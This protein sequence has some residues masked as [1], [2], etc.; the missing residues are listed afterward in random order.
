MYRYI[1]LS[2]STA[3]HLSVNTYT[4]KPCTYTCDGAGTVVS[5]DSIAQ[6]VQQFK[7]SR[8]FR[9][10]RIGHIHVPVGKVNIHVVI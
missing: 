7:T 6:A 4:Y 8:E 10:D 2:A 3:V 1:P 9:S 5:E